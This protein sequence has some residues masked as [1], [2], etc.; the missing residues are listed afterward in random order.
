MPSR[1]GPPQIA[2][3]RLRGSIIVDT[4]RGKV[5]V[6]SWKR[7][8]SRPLHPHTVYMNRW[9]K[10]ACHKIKYADA[11]AVDFAIKAA[12]G[13]GLYPRDI[14]MR[15]TGESLIDLY[16]PDGTPITY[17]KQGIFPVSFQ[18]LITQKNATQS[19]P[20]ATYTPVTWPL[21]QVDTAGIYNGSTPTRFTVPQGVNLWRIEATFWT[22]VATAV[23]IACQLRRNGTT[24]LRDDRK[25]STERGQIAF[26][27]GPMQVT[28]GDYY[29]L[30]ILYQNARTLQGTEITRASVEILDADYPNT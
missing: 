2:P 17:K 20:A 7:K 28:A 22:T 24:V 29:E 10:D 30:L 4:Y 12:K 15:A 11:Q 16:E 9:F 25:G 19:I 1:V 26:D 5:R 6:R 13:T 23:L 21:P 8:L 18:G 3:P 14:L 27:S